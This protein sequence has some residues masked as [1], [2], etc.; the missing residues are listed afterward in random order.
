MYRPVCMQACLEVIL[1]VLWSKSSAKRWR[2]IKVKVIIL[3]DKSHLAL[4]LP[5]KLKLEDG[6]LAY[7]WRHVL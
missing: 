7:T 6:L 3:S 2:D 4:I 1:K 5:P